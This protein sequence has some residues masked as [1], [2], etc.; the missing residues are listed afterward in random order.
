MGDESTATDG[1]STSN[2]TDR[3]RVSARI[4]PADRTRVAGEVDLRM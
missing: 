4:Q 2:P 1:S 3:S